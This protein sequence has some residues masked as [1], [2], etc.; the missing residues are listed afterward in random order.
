MPLLRREN[1]TSVKTVSAY[2]VYKMGKLLD[3]SV[4]MLDPLGFDEYFTNNRF[5]KMATADDAES[6]KGFLSEVVA[7]IS[8]DF[9]KSLDEVSAMAAARDL[10]MVA[11][12]VARFGIPMHECPHLEELLLILAEKTNEVP[13]DTVFGYG[14]RN[15]AGARQRSF[16]KTNE[17]SLFIE[18][19]SAGMN[20]LMVTLAGLETIQSMEISDS[21]YAPFVEESARYLQ[22]MQKAILSVRNHITPDFFTHQLRPF[23]DPKTIRG[24]TYFAA[25]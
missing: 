15:P 11:S 5:S 4:S 3:Q 12:V 22:Q 20:G 25:G 18:S 6:L 23:F 13:T 1:M 7:V 16:T 8:L 24:Q 9:I 21:R 19:F 14:S 17:E 2:V 10:N